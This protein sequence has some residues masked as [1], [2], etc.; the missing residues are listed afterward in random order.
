MTDIL[1]KDQSN[2]IMGACFEVYKEMG[3][4]FLEAVYQECLARE[5]RVRDI[6]SIA[7]PK[8]EIAYK[9]ETLDQTYQ[10]DFVCHGQIILELKAIR[11]LED[12]HRSQLHNY[13]RATNLS[14]GILLNFGASPQ[15]QWE[16]I[17]AA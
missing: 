7:Q 15:L 3:S 17:A 5:F 10:P 16:R 13:L 2:A 14:L 6:P 12:S 11:S 1:F 8:L 9:G 4:G